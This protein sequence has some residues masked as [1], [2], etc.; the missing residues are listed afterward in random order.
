[1][2]YALT[3][4]IKEFTH[5]RY[6]GIVIFGDADAGKTSYMQKFIKLHPQ[7]NIYYI[8][9]QERAVAQPDKSFIFELNPRKFVDWILQLIPSRKVDACIVD[10]FD[11]LFNLWDAVKKEEFIKRFAVTAPALL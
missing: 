1:M 4:L 5:E 11:F 6:I 8:D 7:L 10:H 9:I 3:D 2:P